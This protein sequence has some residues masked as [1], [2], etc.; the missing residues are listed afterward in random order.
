[1]ERGGVHAEIMVIGQAP[2]RSAASHGLAFAGNSFTRLHSWFSEAGYEGTPTDLRKLLYLTSLL[3]CAPTPLTSAIVRKCFGNCRDF[4]I[5]QLNIIDPNLV[6]V[7]G[8]D[9]YDVIR[10]PSPS[11]CDG[12]GSVITTEQVFEG[13]LFPPKTNPCAEWLFLPHP[14]G[15]SRTMNDATVK[16]RLLD[17]LATKLKKLKII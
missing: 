15:L 6:I 17:T 9:A 16:K 8:K 11:F 13:D 12:V 10:Y 1:M 3:K 4:L 14:S 2:G 5:E 7:L